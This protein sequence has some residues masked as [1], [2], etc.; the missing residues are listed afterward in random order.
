MYADLW[1]MLARFGHET[2]EAI[3]LLRKAIRQSI[4]GK[5]A[6]NILPAA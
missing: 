3:D 2:F 1:I 6:R 4:T 5:R